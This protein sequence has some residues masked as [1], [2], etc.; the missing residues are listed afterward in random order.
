MLV[1]QFSFSFTISALSSMLSSLNSR[2]AQLTEKLAILNKIKRQYKINFE[3]YRRLK[4]AL[5][6]DHSKNAAI[7]FGFLNEL[8]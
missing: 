4:M 2:T 1:G 6:Y 7:Q 5:K 8:P 3:F